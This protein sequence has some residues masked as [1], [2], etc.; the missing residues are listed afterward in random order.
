MY[1]LNEIKTLIETTGYSVILA[2]PHEPLLNTLMELPKIYIGYRSIDSRDPNKPEAFSNFEDAAENLTQ[3]FEVQ[4]CCEVID[5]H[6]IWRR[7]YFSLHGKNTQPLESEFSGITYQNGG[8]MGQENNRMW[9][10]DLWGVQF[11][12]SNIFVFN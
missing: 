3:L 9:W 8:L 2:K 12:S 4:I 7:V 11:P 1:P 10:V 6:T 5:L